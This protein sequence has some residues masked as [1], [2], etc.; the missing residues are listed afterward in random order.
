MT[1]TACRGEGAQW[2]EVV[3][4]VW[5]EWGHRALPLPPA[6]LLQYV[7]HSSA[8]SSTTRLPPPQ[9]LSCHAHF[10]TLVAQR[11]DSL[12]VF[13]QIVIETKLKLCPC[14]SA[15]N[16]S[17]MITLPSC[18]PPHPQSLAPLEESRTTSKG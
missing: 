8:P 6:V 17:T 10:S 18:L 13:E 1:F 2:L 15:N 16:N 3:F 7:F 11:D 9:L 4:L 12:F 14:G 5:V